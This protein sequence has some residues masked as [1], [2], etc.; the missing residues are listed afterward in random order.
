MRRISLHAPGIAQ[1]VRDR[2]YCQHDIH[3]EAE[4][5]AV[6]KRNRGPVG[7]D[8]GGERVDRGGERS[9]PGSDHDH[10]H[11]GEAVITQ[12]DDERHE[13]RVKPERFLCHSIGRAAD[14]EDDH[15][16]RDQQ[17]PASPE[18]VGDHRDARLEG[19]GLQRDRDES[20]DGQDEEEHSGRSGKI[21]DVVRAGRAG[22]SHHLSRHLLSIDGAACLAGS[23]GDVGRRRRN[24]V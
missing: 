16:D 3:Q 24:G 11:T 5:D 7:R 9:N 19:A 2:D 14:G 13:D 22:G 6:S 12:P 23:L 10:G 20:S 17:Q 4:P 18:A 8:P 21:P 15:Q 1:D